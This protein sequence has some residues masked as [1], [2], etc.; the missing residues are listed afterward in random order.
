LAQNPNRHAAEI[1]AGSTINAPAIV[2]A[3]IEVMAVNNKSLT[4]RKAEY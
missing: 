4:Q 2:S 3:W 1:L